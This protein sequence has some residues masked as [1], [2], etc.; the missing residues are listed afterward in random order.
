MSKVMHTT[1]R[2]PPRDLKGDL[3]SSYGGLR[4]GDDEL[5]LSE[6]C[7]NKTP[8]PLSPSSS[9]GLRDGDDAMVR[10][11]WCCPFLLIRYGLP[12]QARGRLTRGHTPF[13]HHVAGSTGPPP[14]LIGPFRT[15]PPGATR[16]RVGLTPSDC[17]W[18]DFG[19]KG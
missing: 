3:A 14:T 5:H 8:P 4:D 17:A 2:C 1:K 12:E 16:Q 10:T 18:I 11:F 13:L 15:S 6:L 9:G 19:T 7:F